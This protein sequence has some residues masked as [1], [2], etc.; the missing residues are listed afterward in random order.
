MIPVVETATRSRDPEKS[1][2]PKDSMHGHKYRCSSVDPRARRWQ[3]RC[4]KSQCED[5]D[6]DRDPLWMI[7]RHTSW[8][9]LNEFT[10]SAVWAVKARKELWLKGSVNA[11]SWL[12]SILGFRSVPLWWSFSQF[13]CYTCVAGTHFTTSDV[14]HSSSRAQMC[15]LNYVNLSCGNLCV[16]DCDLFLEESISQY[17]RYLSTWHA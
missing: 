15:T 7:M 10:S 8:T 2:G 4:M 6:A 3:I 14:T 5:D 11:T 9:S 13:W 17:R 16:V 12:T 1:R